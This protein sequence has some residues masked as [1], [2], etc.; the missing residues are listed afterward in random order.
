M[1]KEIGRTPLELDA[2]L[3][4]ELPLLL[5]LAKFVEFVTAPFYLKEEKGVSC[6]RSRFKVDNLRQLIT[7]MTNLN[8]FKRKD[9]V[10]SHDCPKKK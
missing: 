8:M 9:T 5:Q 6:K 3:L 2:L 4:L 10:S 1:A 7:Q